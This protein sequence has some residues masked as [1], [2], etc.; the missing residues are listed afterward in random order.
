[1]HAAH[2]RKYTT[3][4]LTYHLFRKK[5]IIR[6]FLPRYFNQIALRL[7][8]RQATVPKCHPWR[9]GTVFVFYSVSAATKQP[10]QTYKYNHLKA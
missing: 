1:M 3:I 6:F 5:Q 10:Q 4:V 7:T 2:V 9:F 8:Q